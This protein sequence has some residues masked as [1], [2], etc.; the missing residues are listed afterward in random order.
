MH[1]E[2]ETLISD[3]LVRQA[4][5][6]PHPQTVLNRLYEPTAS[7]PR[8]RRMLLVAAAAVAA[9]AVGASTML[10]HGSG[11]DSR[12]PEVGVGAAP[13]ASAGA[14]SSAAKPA[15][16]G[17]ALKYKAGWLPEGYVEKY[18]ESWLDNSDQNRTWVKGKG[19]GGSRGSRDDDAATHIN[20]ELITAKNGSAA[21]IQSES[22]YPTVVKTTVKG[23]PAYFQPLGDNA[24]QL[25]WAA[26]DSQ[27]LQLTLA[28]VPDLQATATRIAESVVADG[29]AQMQNPFVP[30]TVPGG[31]KPIDASVYGE[32][33]QTWGAFMSFGDGHDKKIF[34]AEVRHSDP[35]VTGGRAVTVRGKQGSFTTVPLSSTGAGPWGRTFMA[36]T[37]VLTVQLDDGLWLAV[38]ASSANQQ[39]PNPFTEQDLVAFANGLTIQPGDNAWLGH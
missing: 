30:G 37:T 3:T 35:G 26:S 13:S 21:F 15:A 6:A 29:S 25:T 20:M 7:V 5:R 10:L 14:P 11:G 16:A 12:A 18:R 27:V 17:I 23:K 28:A 39:Q 33:A 32:S 2:T 4:D 31:I 34:G 1:D 8:Q 9:V 22:Q 19:F 38:S 24:I 36:S